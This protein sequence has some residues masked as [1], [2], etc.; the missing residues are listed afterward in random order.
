M[1]ACTYTCKSSSGVYVCW[2]P[3]PFCWYRKLWAALPWDLLMCSVMP[4]AGAG[5]G[6]SLWQLTLAKKLPSAGMA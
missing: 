1:S 4:P 2:K 5:W 3:C 6:G